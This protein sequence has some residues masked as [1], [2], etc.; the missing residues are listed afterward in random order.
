M[1]ARELTLIRILGA[2]YLLIPAAAVSAQVGPPKVIE[3]MLGMR[4]LLVPA[5]EFNMGTEDVEAAR[6]EIP[7]PK[8]E[9]VWDETPAHRVIIDR[10][11]YL[12]E[13]EVTQGVWLDL[14]ENKPGP[15]A[16]W[17]R[18]DWRSLPV[19]AASWF[20]AKRFI[21]EL[22]ALDPRYR[23][24]LPTEAEWEYAARGG[25]SGMR[26]VPDERLD[27][28]AW[29]ILNSGDEPHPV[30]KLG[31]NAFGFYDMLGNVWEWVDDWYAPDAY[32]DR[33]ATSPSGP[34]SGLSKVRR[35]GSYHCPV[36]LVRPAYRGA[37]PPGT[38][39]S[40]LGFR[41]VAEPK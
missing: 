29:F 10:P 40:V 37:N 21:E 12:G 30:A 26:P 5:G 35:G 38:R 17:N 24:R 18:D 27:E 34:E 16:F 9:D 13:T 23:Y 39:Y 2:L 36:H 4:F 20:M 19:A 14:M 25:T 3:N 8:P 32:A 1:E 22:S 31:A 33:P 15:D 6:M 41:L 7:E 11:F 28:H